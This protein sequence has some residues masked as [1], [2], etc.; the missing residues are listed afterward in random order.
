MAIRHLIWCLTWDNK[1]VPGAAT[2]IRA[3]RPMTLAR[4]WYPVHTPAPLWYLR[5]R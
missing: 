3:R 1:D 4:L 5:T 2:P